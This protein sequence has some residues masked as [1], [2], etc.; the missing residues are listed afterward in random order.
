LFGE[1]EEETVGDICWG[2]VI[3]DLKE[4]MLMVRSEWFWLR[5]GTSANPMNEDINPEVPQ[6]A[7]I[8]LTR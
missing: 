6:T 7:G 2:N 5:I 3:I 4:M 1:P 8:V